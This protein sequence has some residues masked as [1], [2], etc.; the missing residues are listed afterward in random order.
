MA[1][2]NGLRPARLLV[3]ERIIRH[4]TTRSG[5]VIHEIVL[6]KESF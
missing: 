6:M 3:P 5:I 2:H 1:R 4:Q